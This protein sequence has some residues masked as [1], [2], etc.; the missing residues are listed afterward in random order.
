[1]HASFTS[2]NLMLLK[3]IISQTFCDLSIFSYSSERRTLCYIFHVLC[4]KVIKFDV[5][6][7]QPFWNSETVTAV[8]QGH[9]GFLKI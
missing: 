4:R 7:S 3:S 5:V 2:A 8:F 6:C 1:M 9:L